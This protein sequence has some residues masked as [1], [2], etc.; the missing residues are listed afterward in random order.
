[1]EDID[2]SLEGNKNT[3]T[4]PEI[5]QS[6]TPEEIDSPKNQTLKYLQYLSIWF[7]ILFSIAWIYF[8][9]VTPTKGII[10]DK[11]ITQTTTPDYSKEITIH[12]T[13]IWDS[14]TIHYPITQNTS[15]DGQKILTWS[16]TNTL[17]PGNEMADDYRAFMLQYNMNVITPL[18]SLYKTEVFANNAANSIITITK[19]FDSYYQEYQKMPET[20]KRDLVI[21]YIRE[22]YQNYHGS[23]QSLIDLANT[24]NITFLKDYFSKVSNLSDS[25]V[26]YIDYQHE[27]HF[28]NDTWNNTI[29]L[30]IDNRGYPDE[31]AISI[32]NKKWKLLKA[33]DFIIQATIDEWNIA[34]VTREDGQYA[35][36]SI[37]FNQ[38]GSNYSPQIT[39]SLQSKATGNTFLKKFVVKFSK[40]VSLDTRLIL[41][42]S[43]RIPMIPWIEWEVYNGKIFADT[44]IKI[45]AFPTWRF[46]HTILVYADNPWEKLPWAPVTALY[47][48][49]D[50]GLC[51]FQTWEEFENFNF[52]KYFF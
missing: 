28:S 44:Q 32:Y 34:A 18:K 47:Q 17:L 9:I 42:W 25:D 23:E 45:I 31:D 8:F 1:M 12:E 6:I 49:G 22:Y 46:F 16:Y 3:D 51:G 33:S 30:A 38:R 11:I 4:K 27:Y 21:N 37:Q 14:D 43:K 15:Q 41:A 2:S 13:A 26:A 10:E 48:N 35:D 19:T 24:E 36:I 20:F 5:I 40:E 29:Y 52:I 7:S 50:P 39:L